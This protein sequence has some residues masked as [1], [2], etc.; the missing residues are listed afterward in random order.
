MQFSCFGLCVCVCWKKTSVCVMHFPPTGDLFGGKPHCQLWLLRSPG[1]VATFLLPSPAH[2]S[3]EGRQVTHGG[4]LLRD[5]ADSPPSTAEE[6]HLPARFTSS[7]PTVNWNKAEAPPIL[8]EWD[9]NLPGGKPA[10]S[11]R[12]CWILILLITWPAASYS[13]RDRLGSALC[14]QRPAGHSWSSGRTGRSDPVGPPELLGSQHEEPS[15]L[16][17]RHDHHRLRIGHGVLIVHQ[18]VQEV[19]A[20]PHQHLWRD[21]KA[22]RPGGRPPI[23]GM[24]KDPHAMDPF[25]RVSLPLL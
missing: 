12:K 22:A 9:M 1:L 20:Q 3:L 16:Q 2:S 8:N 23:Q 25:E 11:W 21:A 5:R 14:P 10:A 17:G 4:H 13:Q 18:V 19:L 6:D 24:D 7:M 15:Q